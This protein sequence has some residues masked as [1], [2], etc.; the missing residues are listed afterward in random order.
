VFVPDVRCGTK[1]EKV[2]VCHKG[3]TIC[4]AKEAVAA[5]LKHSDVLGSCETNSPASARMVNENSPVDQNHFKLYNYP[6]PFSNT[7][8]ILF[9]LPNDGRVVIKLYDLSGKEI[10][11]LL[12]ADRKAGQYVLP[13]SP[14]GLP[15]GVYYYKISYSTSG[16]YFSKTQK[17]L[18]TAH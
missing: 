4:V 11:T 16:K 17:L 5:H 2:Q 7:T 15:G 13:F 14:H 10:T 18:I 6:N 3:E 1:M 12:S 9:E 8:R